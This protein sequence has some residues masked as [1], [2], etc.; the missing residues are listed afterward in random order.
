MPEE[1]IFDGGGVK[2]TGLGNVSGN[3]FNVGSGISGNALT[4]LQ[5]YNQQLQNQSLNHYLP[6][7]VLM[8]WATP[9]ASRKLSAMKD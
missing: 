3:P 5:N 1:N 9:S 8:K 7:M 2:T 6:C 4:G